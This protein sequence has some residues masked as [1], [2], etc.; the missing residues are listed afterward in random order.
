MTGNSTT[1]PIARKPRK[2]KPKKPKKPYDDFPL[3]AH[4][5]G[6]W[7]KKVLGKLHYFGSWKTGTWQAALDRWKAEQEDLRAGR[8]PRAKTEGQEEGQGLKLHQL[9]NA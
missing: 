4:R 3:M 5:N 8:K 1:L 6:L 9:L 7:C 2:K